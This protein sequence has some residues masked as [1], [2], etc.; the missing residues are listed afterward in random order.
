MVPVCRTVGF[1]RLGGR[2]QDRADRRLGD[3]AGYDGP[4]K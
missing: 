3:V 2:L 1:Q 4:E